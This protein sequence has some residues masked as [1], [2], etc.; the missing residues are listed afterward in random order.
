[1]SARTL[2]RSGLLVAALGAVGSA[3]AYFFNVLGTCDANGT[4][5]STTAEFSS[6]PEFGNNFSYFTLFF[7]NGDFQSDFTN[8]ASVLDLVGTG[9]NVVNANNTY[10]FSGQYTVTNAVNTTVP[11]GSTGTYSATFDLN[12]GFFSYSVAGGPVPE[13]ASMA[14]LGLGSLALLRRRRSR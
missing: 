9:G 2:C 3:N 5:T 14:A 12:A 6:L 8:G 7:L 13:P 1:M 11:L 4:I 10:S